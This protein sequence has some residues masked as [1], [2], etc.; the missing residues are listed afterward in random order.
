MVESMLGNLLDLEPDMDLWTW[1]KDW[2]GAGRDEVERWPLPSRISKD[3]GREPF[4]FGHQESRL[5]SQA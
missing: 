1:T 4:F 3:E 5:V 2:T